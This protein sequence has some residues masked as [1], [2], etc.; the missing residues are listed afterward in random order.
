M[1]IKKGDTIPGIF[2]VLIGAFVLIHNF[3]HPKMNI[4]AD[5]TRGGVGPGFF[6]FI[7]GIA[8]VLFGSVLVIRGIKQNGTV[9]YFQMTAEKAVNLKRVALLVGVIAL[10]LAA[11]KISKIFYV[12]LP[13]YC[14]SLNK[15]VLKQ[16]TKF[17]IIFTVI[18][19]AFIYALFTVAFTVRFMP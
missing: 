15:F 6:P 12:C 1:L 4:L 9:D 3:L 13:I 7:C 14:F 2:S 17:S 5:A 19:T 11:W 8:L 10:M 18:I 16:S